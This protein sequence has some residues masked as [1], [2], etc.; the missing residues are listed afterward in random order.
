MA[1]LA[2][3]WQSS[4]S[5]ILNCSSFLQHGQ[6]GSVYAAFGTSS[7]DSSSSE[8]VRRKDQLSISY[9][10]S[11]DQ[12]PALNHSTRHRQPCM[13]RNAKQYY[14]TS[15]Q[16]SSRVLNTYRCRYVQSQCSLHRTR[17]YD[18]VRRRWHTQ[19]VITDEVQQAIQLVCDQ[20]K[21]LVLSEIVDNL[22]CYL[23]FSSHT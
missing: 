18:Q 4:S 23:A 12:N 21:S 3:S 15:C 20:S 1:V 17:G 14:L 13:G 2:S 16:Q 7:V 11:C 10:Q 9:S 6:P 22:W 8:N 5:P 19:P